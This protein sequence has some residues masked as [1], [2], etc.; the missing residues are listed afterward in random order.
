MHNILIYTE[1]TA[2]MTAEW[3]LMSRINDRH[4]YICH[5]DM[6]IV[7]WPR[8]ALETRPLGITVRTTADS[9]DD[10]RRELEQGGWVAVP[11]EVAASI[12]L[13]DEDEW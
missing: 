10:A 6:A 1:G 11:K 12:A 13:F 2:T 9:P 7:T 8:E 4:V 3:A 5:V